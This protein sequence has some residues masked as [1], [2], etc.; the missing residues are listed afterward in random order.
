M[1]RLRSARAAGKRVEILR[2]IGAASASLAVARENA[3]R[4]SERN[5]R[6][7]RVARILDAQGE[8]E[9]ECGVSANQVQELLSLGAIAR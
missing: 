8:R 5:K 3:Q 6:G 2:H 9:F 1:D 4:A 7:E